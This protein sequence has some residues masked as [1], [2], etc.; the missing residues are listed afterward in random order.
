MSNYGDILGVCADIA[1]NAL[2]DVARDLYLVASRWMVWYI[3][4]PIKKRDLSGIILGPECIESGRAKVL[5][6]V[7][8]RC[9]DFKSPVGRL[10]IVNGA[11]K[12]GGR[13]NHVVRSGEERRAEQKEAQLNDLA[14]RRILPNFVR[15]GVPPVRGG[16]ALRKFKSCQSYSKFGSE[17][18]ISRPGTERYGLQIAQMLI[19]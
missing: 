1:E 7:N 19:L 17:I 6:L 10:G 18:V 9:L 16:V 11:G 3:R 14:H 4:T 13:A 12:L 2:V 15:K 5:W 8:E